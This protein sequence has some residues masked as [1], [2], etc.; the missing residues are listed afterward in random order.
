MKRRVFLL[1]STVLSFASLNAQTTRSSQG[2][3]SVRNEA[4]S[5]PPV[6]ERVLF[7][8]VPELLQGIWQGADR[9][10]MFSN[11]N[12]FALVLRVFYQWYNDRAA[13]PASFSEIKSRDRNN[14]TKSPAED[15]QI[16]YRTIVENPSKNAG[17][18]ELSIK[19]PHEKDPVL[20]PICIIDGKIYMDFLI[21]DSAQVTDLRKGGELSEKSDSDGFYRAASNAN[22][23]MI[24]SPI[25]KKEVI[26]YFMGGEGEVYRIRYWLSEMDYSYAKASFTDGDKV[27]S[28]DK[29]LRIGS[30]VYQCTTGRSSKIRNIQK[31]TK[32][33]K[34][35][36]Y[37]SDGGIVAFGE[38]YL[39]KVPEGEDR[40]A[41]ETSAYFL[42]SVGEN[43]K[44]RHPAPK[45][46]FP[47][48]FPKYRWKEITELEL[49]NPSTWNK[50]NLDIHK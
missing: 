21:K 18:Y 42:D 32:F 45:P 29:Y 27:F 40:T 28:V 9:L 3:V 12:E 19:Y 38:P 39:V 46:L 5:L 24:S 30:S 44:R 1:I 4:D 13:E 10:V 7:E 47:P 8:N 43:N 6:T 35:A 49:Y 33:D 2:I 50:R 48:T 23:I 11:K 17:V 36:A 31:S 26:S 14:T 37:D 41:L 20:V 16:Q 15:I 25:F 22:G 34:N